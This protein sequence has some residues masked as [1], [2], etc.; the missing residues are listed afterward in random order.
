M[1]LAPPNGK[2]LEACGITAHVEP[3]GQLSEAPRE[4]SD[5]AIFF[6]RE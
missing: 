6:V 5:S 1:S 2:I 3:V 4:H